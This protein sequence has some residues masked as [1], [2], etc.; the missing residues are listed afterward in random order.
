M[1]K[2]K[3]NDIVIDKENNEFRITRIDGFNHIESKDD[4]TFIPTGYYDCETIEEQ[5]YK[6][7]YEDELI[8]K[9]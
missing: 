8:K 6:R 5:K 1:G 4:I 3:E 9:E 2:F 7:F